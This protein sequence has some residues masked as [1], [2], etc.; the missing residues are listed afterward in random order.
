MYAIERRATDEYQRP[1]WQ[2]GL[3]RV[4]QVVT[5]DEARCWRPADRCEFGHWLLLPR[6][7]PLTLFGELGP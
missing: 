2:G 6:R 5:C 1:A 4:L 7:E 3:V